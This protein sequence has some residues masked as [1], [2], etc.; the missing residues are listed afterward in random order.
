MQIR[1]FTLETPD[2]V[3][4][5]A[6]ILCSFALPAMDRYILAYT[7]NEEVSPGTLRLYLAAAVPLDQGCRLHRPDAA[8]SQAAL[9]ALAAIAT[10]DKAPQAE[11]SVFT[12]IKLEGPFT[13]EGAG[14][15]STAGH[16]SLPIDKDMALK[17]IAGSD[18]SAASTDSATERVEKSCANAP[19]RDELEIARQRNEA[20]SE[21]LQS[22]AEALDQ[23]E[24]MLARKTAELA[25]Q[26]RKL[27]SAR[28]KL[29]ALAKAYGEAARAGNRRHEAS[30]RTIADR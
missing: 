24:A 1:T 18:L 22:R 28:N 27:L 2:K 16:A 26:T 15:A 12:L 30:P 11:S 29:S 19:A 25:L 17:L 6:A 10:L 21:L 5:N 14:P 8:E 20:W 13:G 9:R 4:V 7:L 3:T 23:R